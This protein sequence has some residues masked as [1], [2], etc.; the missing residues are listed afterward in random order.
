MPEIEITLSES[1]ARRLRQLAESLGTTAEQLAADELR[2]RYLLNSS[3][4][5][6]VPLRPKTTGSDHGHD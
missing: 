3:G 4:G 2:R 5:T 1:E 6:V